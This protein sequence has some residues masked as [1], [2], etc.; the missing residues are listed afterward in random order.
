ME[1]YLQQHNN[2]SLFHAV[3]LGQAVLLRKTN[4]PSLVL[5]DEAGEGVAQRL[6]TLLQS[7]KVVQHAGAT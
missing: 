3:H 6:D 5:C 7:G 1:G 4:D 2:F